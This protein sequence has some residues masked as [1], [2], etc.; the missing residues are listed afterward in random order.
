[1]WQDL[2]HYIC[3]V[4]ALPRE[5]LLDERV[6]NYSIDFGESFL[7]DIFCQQLFQKGHACCSFRKNQ[8]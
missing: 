7:D 8:I 6:K 1:V 4:K 3:G 2:P 5:G